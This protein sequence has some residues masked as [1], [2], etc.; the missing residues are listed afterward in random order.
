M[1]QYGRE[2][3][4]NLSEDEKEKRDEYRKKYYKARK[5]MMGQINLLQKKTKKIIKE[6]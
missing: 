3:Q 4:K 6:N 5:R 1:Q 2:C